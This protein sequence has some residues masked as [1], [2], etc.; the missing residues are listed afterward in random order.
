MAAVK[1]IERLVESMK[2]DWRAETELD[3]EM[4]RKVGGHDGDD[5]DNEDH[6]QGNRKLRC[7][8]RRE[9]EREES[10]RIQTP[11][12]QEETMR[13]GREEGIGGWTEEKRSFF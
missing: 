13:I 1:R 10:T 11:T 6:S 3:G 9:D 12:T 2:P 7:R 8:G 4:A 5:G